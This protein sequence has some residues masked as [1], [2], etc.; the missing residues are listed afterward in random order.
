MSTKNLKVKTGISSKDVSFDTPHVGMVLP[1]AGTAAPSGWLMCNGSAVSSTTYPL[2]YALV[3]ATTP[4]LRGKYVV[5]TAGAVNSS[6]GANNH[7]HTQTYSATNTDTKTYNHSHY[8]YNNATYSG[9]SVTW[10]ASNHSHAAN[11]TPYINAYG[12]TTVSKSG[13][14][15]GNLTNRNHNHAATGGY[16]TANINAGYVVDSHAIYNATTNADSPTH[17]HTVAA[18]GTETLSSNTTINTPPTIYVN[19][20][21]KA[22]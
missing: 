12:N 4:D 8:V 17:S 9:N 11:H 5:G 13:T 15:Q 10:V 3:G 14:S 1:F 6:A 20:I 2:L 22:G 7:T 19:F 18:S 21:I 16:W